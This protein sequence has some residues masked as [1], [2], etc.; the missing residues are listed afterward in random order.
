MPPKHSSRLPSRHRV[1][2]AVCSAFFI[3]HFSFFIGAALAEPKPGDTVTNSIGMK[4][5]FIPAGE[6]DMGSPADQKGHEEDETLHRVRITRAFRM[7][8][9]EV[10]QAQ[11]TKV[12]GTRRGEF[13]G[14]DLSVESISYADA[15]EFCKKVSKAEGR[16]YRLPTEAEW[17]YACRA[18]TPG[19]LAPNVD[20]LAWFD[21]NA[22]GKTHAVGSKKP[23]AWGLYDMHGNVAEWCSD[24][25]AP[26]PSGPAV[27]PA[28]SATG[29]SRVVRGG[30]FASFP[31]GLR[32]SSRGNMPAS[33]QLKTV[34]LRVV[35][36][37]P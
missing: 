31:R 5:A 6:F 20:D 1:F 28:G 23:N 25:Y 3:F 2:A 8:V 22:E 36:E 11:W 4:L 12:T 35:V 32:S 37:E 24:Y 10:T 19:P 9:T 17:E 26:Y 16:T 27:D 18:G 7:S 33:Y 13:Q 21:D 29:K 30:S 15:V 14:D 34:G